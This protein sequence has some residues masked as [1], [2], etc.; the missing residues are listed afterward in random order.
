MEIDIS[1]HLVTIFSR[2]RKVTTDTIAEDDGCGSSAGRIGAGLAVVTSMIARKRLPTLRRSDRP[3]CKV[4][5]SHCCSKRVIALVPEVILIAEQIRRHGTRDAVLTKLADVHR[6]VAGLSYQEH[7]D[8]GIP[9]PLL[10]A[11]GRCSVYDARPTTCASWSS[12][13]ANDCIDPRGQ[14]RFYPMPRVEQLAAM[15]G[16]MQGLRE[17]GLGPLAVELVAGVKI[18]LEDEHAAARWLAGEPIFEGAKAL[19]E[20][21]G[22]LVSL[23]D[24]FVAWREA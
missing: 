18:A 7:A 3:A 10:G 5:C 9:C 2:T 8:L 11:S 21:V 20:E 13:D 19:E 4:G 23:L 12:V 6:V 14:T 24:Q 22:S 1:D 16:A 15:A 17:V